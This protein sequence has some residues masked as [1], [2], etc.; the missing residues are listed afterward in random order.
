[1]RTQ[2]E[3]RR[4]LTD[5]E[6]SEYT[7]AFYRSS[8]SVRN[9][10]VTLT[11]AAV[12]IFT[13]FWNSYAG[14]WTASRVRIA[15][16]ALEN[17]VWDR[18][19]CANET[20]SIVSL[21]CSWARL[22]GLESSEAVKEHL[23]NLDLKYVDTV[24]TV[25]APVLGVAFDV[26]DLGIFG[27]IAF[28]FLLGWLNFALL[29]EHENLTLCTWKIKK[30]SETEK[31]DPGGQA[32]LLYHALA[33]GQ[34]LSCPPTLSRR[35]ARPLQNQLTKLPLFVPAMVHTIIFAYDMRSMEF[36]TSL[37]E[38]LAW[39]GMWIQTTACVI[40]IILTFSCYNTAMKDDRQWRVTFVQ[41]NPQ[42]NYTDLTSKNLRWLVFDINPKLC[43]LIKGIIAAVTPR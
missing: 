33:M 8:N 15:R 1:M 3:S 31:G 30:L 6:F 32:N 37:N 41:A 5:L 13:G 21:A 39:I 43:Q 14:G 35:R 42:F 26:N 34:L 29:R 22:R 19:T 28:I 17:E 4:G 18:S 2:R 23:H 38:N 25:R 36:A 20:N 40:N 16:A 10:L 24:L 9:I 27:G 7:R 12:V 11:I